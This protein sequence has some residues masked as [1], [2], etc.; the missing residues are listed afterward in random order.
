MVR[1]RPVAVLRALEVVVDVSEEAAGV[2]ARVA[3]GV[4]QE[5]DVVVQAGAT[6]AVLLAVRDVSNG[7]CCQLVV[8]DD[9]LVR[10]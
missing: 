6:S 4:L 8:V 9:I 10:V 3:R 2:L 7:A 5:H 1:R